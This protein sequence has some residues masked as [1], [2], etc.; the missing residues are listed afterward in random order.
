[1]S[2]VF[3]IAARAEWEA[4]LAAGVYRTG[5]LDGEGF[6][7]CSTAEQADATANTLFVG[8]ADLVLLHIEV[9]RLEAPLRYDPVAEPRGA[10]FPHIYGPLNLAAVFDVIALQ[11]GADGRFELHLEVRA[12][13]ATADHTLE[14]TETRAGATMQ[15]YR[16]PWWVAG[17]WSVEL[18]V[19]AAHGRGIRPHA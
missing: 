4:A 15:A 6:I 7:H 9:E 2:V 1:M 18:Q 14:Q 16:G 12:L 13:A 5:S 19:A 11:P 3:H 17:G 8:R 10:V